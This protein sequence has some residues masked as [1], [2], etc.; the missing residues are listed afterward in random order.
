[1]TSDDLELL[2][3]SSI[4]LGISHGFANLGDIND[5]QRLNERKWTRIVSDKIVV[6]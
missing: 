6:H 2:A 1:M 4:F 5:N 3:I